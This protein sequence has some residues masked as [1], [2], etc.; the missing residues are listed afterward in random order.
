MHMHMYVYVYMHL[1]ICMGVAICLCLCICFVHIHM[2]YRHTHTLYTFVHTGSI[3][4]LQRL[5]RQSIHALSLSLSPPAMMFFLWVRQSMPVL[6]FAITR[7]RVTNLATP[8]TFF[9]ACFYNHR[10]SRAWATS[11][12]SFWLTVGALTATNIMVQYAQNN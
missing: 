3:G 8:A 7:A 4:L 5:S 1:I 2:P 9:A 12:E 6:T 11:C 10:L